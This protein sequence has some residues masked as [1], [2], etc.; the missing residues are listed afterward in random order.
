MPKCRVLVRSFINNGLREEG[1]IVDYDGKIGSNLELVES[2]KD[3][4]PVEKAQSKK[5]WAKLKRGDAAEG[6]V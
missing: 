3:D 1:D 2:E 6:S 4:A 5:P